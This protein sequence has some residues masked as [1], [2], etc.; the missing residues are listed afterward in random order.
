MFIL[1]LVLVLIGW[2]AAIP[3][4]LWIGVILLV[5]GA[6]LMLAPNLTGGRRLY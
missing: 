6:V 5:V 1:G 2:L 4:L 3:I